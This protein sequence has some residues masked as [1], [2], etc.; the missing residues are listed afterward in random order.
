MGVRIRERVAADVANATVIDLT[1]AIC[2]GFPCRVVRKGVVMFRDTHHLTNTYAAT[3][4][5][6]LG[7]GLDRALD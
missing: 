5:D 1:T 6:A 7:A 2:A 3:L 4:R